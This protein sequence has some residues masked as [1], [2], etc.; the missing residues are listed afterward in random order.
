M[1]PSRPPPT[2]HFDSRSGRTLPLERS[3]RHLVRSIA[4]KCTATTASPQA[5]PKVLR[6]TEELRICKAQASRVALLDRWTDKNIR[7]ELE[8]VLHELPD[9][10]ASASYDFR[11]D[12]YPALSAIDEQIPGVGMQY[13][14][15][16]GATPR[17]PFAKAVDVVVR[18]LS[19]VP[20]RLA[21]PM[22]ANVMARE[23]VSSG[24]WAM[25]RLLAT[26]GV[27]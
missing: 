4:A 13:V 9:L 19:Y 7:A 11:H 1:G 23:V 18:P 15:W 8:Q 27:V 16:E 12:L 2:R 24:R 3:G 10:V 21:T 20:Y 25:K 26:A 6:C 14:H 17:F 22:M 5:L